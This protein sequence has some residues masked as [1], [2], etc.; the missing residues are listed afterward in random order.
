MA[1]PFPFL[2]TPH[3]SPK[4]IGLPSNDKPTIYNAIALVGRGWGLRAAVGLGLF[5]LSLSLSLSLEGEGIMGV[6]LFSTFLH[7]P[8][9][10]G[11]ALFL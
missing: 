10:L 1:P 6:A 9:T 11:L 3:I 2:I 8:F 4:T 7:Y 5:T